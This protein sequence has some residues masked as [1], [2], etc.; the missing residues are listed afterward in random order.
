MPLGMHGHRERGAGEGGDSGQ[1][2]SQKARDRAE[3]GMRGRGAGPWTDAGSAVAHFLK[4]AH[5]KFHK[6][7]PWKYQA[8]EANAHRRLSGIEERQEFCPCG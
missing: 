8:S 6:R 2:K 4:S 5:C 7:L 3:S 1:D